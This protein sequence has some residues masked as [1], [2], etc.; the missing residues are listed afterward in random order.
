M[1]KPRYG[2]NVDLILYSSGVSAF[3]SL[4]SAYPLHFLGVVRSLKPHKIAID[5]MLFKAD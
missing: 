4:F 1:R 5:V 2:M 3:T